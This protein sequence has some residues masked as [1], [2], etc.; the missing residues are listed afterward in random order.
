M[1]K[2]SRLPRVSVEPREG[3]APLFTGLF[4]PETSEKALEKGTAGG[5]QCTQRPET[6]ARKLFQPASNLSEQVDTSLQQHIH[7]LPEHEETTAGCICT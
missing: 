4:R 5:P 1:A 3:E 6:K 7:R 2:Q